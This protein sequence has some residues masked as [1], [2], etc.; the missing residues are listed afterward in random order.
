MLKK[1]FDLPIWIH[2]A[3]TAGVL[4]A[5]QAI[6]GRLDAL[7]AASGHPVDYATGQLAFDGD[8]IKGYY[9]VMDGKGTLDVYVST[10]QFDYLFMLG[11]AALGLCL[12]TLIG[13]LS[14]DGSWG[15]RIGVGVAFAAMAGAC[16][17]AV[18]NAVSFVMLAQP[19]TFSN[20]LALPYSGFAAAKFM[21]ITLA[22]ALLLVSLFSAGAGRLLGKPKIG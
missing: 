7:Y 21:M 3:V 2:A 12:G 15:R 14:R 11:I 1:F 4:A 16:F 10:Q 5:F 19:E 20:A 18:E 22:M 8:L 13:R 9:A 17:D 6:K